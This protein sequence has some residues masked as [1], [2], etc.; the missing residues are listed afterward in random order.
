MVFLSGAASD[1]LYSILLDTPPP[2]EQER[3]GS[4]REIGGVNPP[5]TLEIRW[6]P[7][8]GG[9][10]TLVA[11]A[12]NG[13]GPHFARNDSTRVYITTPRGLQSITMDG[14]DRRTHLRVQGSGPGNNPPGA[15]EIRL[16]PDG[17]RA[18]VSL[19]GKHFLWRCLAPGARRSK[20]TCRVARNPR[21][22][23]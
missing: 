23:R 15:E 9:A 13:R 20:C 22:C 10:T 6:M 2:D 4:L 7:A 19:Q 17:T 12:Q 18:F 3:D 11:S 21:P 1:Q 8:A 5:N 14:Y 16:S